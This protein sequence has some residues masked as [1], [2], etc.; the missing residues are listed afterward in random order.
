MDLDKNLTKQTKNSRPRRVPLFVRLFYPPKD[1]TDV[2]K[3]LLLLVVYF[4][5]AL[6]YLYAY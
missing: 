5:P 4:W 1:A 6:L 3:K 2:V